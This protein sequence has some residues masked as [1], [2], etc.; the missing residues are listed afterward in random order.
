MDTLTG[1]FDMKI[2]I[3]NGSPKGKRGNTHV[4]V[5]SLIQGLEQGGAQVEYVFLNKKEIKHCLGCLNCWIKTPGVCVHKDDMAELI[6]IYMS[7]DVVALATPLYVDNISGMTKVFMDRL[8]PTVDPHFE[9]DETGETRHVKSD[10]ECPK[11]MIIASCGFPEQSQFQVL[12][13][14]FRRIA[15][16]M[17]GELVAEIYRAQGN[18]LTIK[19]DMLAPIVAGYK[20]LL[21]K[22]GREFAENGKLS[23]ETVAALD[24]PLVPKDMYVDGANRH[25]DRSL[26]AARKAAEEG[27]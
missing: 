22:A 17:Q 21:V 27:K 3:F 8:I 5:E 25:W 11:M 7:S 14:L 9:D 18:L 15:R 16:N 23:E 12:Q 20:D 26:A 24:K 19:H 13:L 1:G 10:R 4:M 2:A 6:D